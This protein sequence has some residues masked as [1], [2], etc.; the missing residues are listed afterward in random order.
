MSTALAS[1]IANTIIMQYKQNNRS[2]AEHNETRKDSGRREKQ[3][4]NLPLNKQS[5]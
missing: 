3:A 4:K 1:K 5:L 2:T